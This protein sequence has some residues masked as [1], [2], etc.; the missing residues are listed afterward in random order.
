MEIVQKDY[1]VPCLVQLNYQ[2]AAT[3]HKL[4]SADI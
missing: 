2:M 1:A 4:S 3:K